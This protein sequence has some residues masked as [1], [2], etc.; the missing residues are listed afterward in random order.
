ML[1]RNKRRDIDR[2]HRDPRLSRPNM[3]IG[4]GWATGLII[5]LK[6]GERVQFRPRGGSMRGKVPS[7]ALCTVEP[8]H[9]IASLRVGDVVLCT[10]RGAQYLHLIKAIREGQFLIGNNVGGINGWISAPSIHGRLVSLEP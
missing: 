5:R 1:H 10:V 9:N 6:A 2:T 4:K 3:G 7:G 8:V